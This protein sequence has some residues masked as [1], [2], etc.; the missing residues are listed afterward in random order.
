LI[1]VFLKGEQEMNITID[2]GKLPDY[3]VITGVGTVGLNIVNAERKLDD[4]PRIAILRK[5]VAEVKLLIAEKNIGEITI[6]NI[7]FPKL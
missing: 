2:F 4:R 7:I 5:T 6:D 1:K 3:A